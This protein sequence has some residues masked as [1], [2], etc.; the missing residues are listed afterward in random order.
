MRDIVQKQT[1]DF[2]MHV[3]KNIIS[4]PRFVFNRCDSLM[5]SITLDCCRYVQTIVESCLFKRNNYCAAFHIWYIGLRTTNN[6][7]HYYD[8]WKK[9]H[10]SLWKEDD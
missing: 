6:N 4:L 10:A 8:P 3:K 2:S 9:F 5:L 7:T 1:V